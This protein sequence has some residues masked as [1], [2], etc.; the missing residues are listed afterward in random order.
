MGKNTE[1][2]TYTVQTSTDKGVLTVLLQVT[3]I[4]RNKLKR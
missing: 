2:L 3:V 4:V 1:I